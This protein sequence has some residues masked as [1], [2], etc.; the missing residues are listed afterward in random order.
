MG[1]KRTAGEAGRDAGPPPRRREPQAG[2]Q[3]G[4]ERNGECLSRGNGR[5]LRPGRGQRNCKGAHVRVKCGPAFPMRSGGKAA[6]FPCSHAPG[7][8][9]GNPGPR[10]VPSRALC[11]ASRRAGSPAAQAT[12]SGQTRSGQ[13]GP[14]EPPAALRPPAGSEL[15]VLPGAA[16]GARRR[17][18][19]PRGAGARRGP[20]GAGR[21]RKL[22]RRRA[23]LC[24]C[25]GGAGVSLCNF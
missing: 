12:G 7:R 21:H 14:R 22:G 25:A 24:A 3:S 6:R 10:C 23:R 19:A 15:R 9:C 5:E 2:L 1:Q 13:L 11:A 18:W 16:A 8:R 20:R 17:G 4:A